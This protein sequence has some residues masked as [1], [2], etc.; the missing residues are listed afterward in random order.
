MTSSKMRFIAHSSQFPVSRVIWLDDGTR[1]D[2]AESLRERQRQRRR[3]DLARRS[4]EP[5]VPV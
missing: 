5:T 3:A 1:D 4:C 2:S